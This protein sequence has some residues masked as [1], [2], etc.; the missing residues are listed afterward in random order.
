[1]GVGA[2]TDA[3]TGAEFGTDVATQGDALAQDMAMDAAAR[4]LLLLTTFHGCGDPVG[5]SG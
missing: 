2:G 3:A 5:I 1:M 4:R